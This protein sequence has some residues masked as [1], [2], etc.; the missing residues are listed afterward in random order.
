MKKK[1]LVLPAVVGLGIVGY[2]ASPLSGPH[3]LTSNPSE[4]QQRVTESVQSVSPHKE[5]TIFFDKG[6]NDSLLHEN[7]I[8]VLDDRNHAIPVTIQ[9]QDPYTITVL[10]PKNGY[11]FGHT[12]HLYIH[13]DLDLE[14]VNNTN[15]P[16]EYHV[17]F[18]VNEQ[19]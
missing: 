10:P 15:L 7:G 12:Y 14:N 1:A 5:F 18:H 16:N 11:E 4:P 9:K 17:P 2:L 19:M 6:M 3:E 8:Y 13:R